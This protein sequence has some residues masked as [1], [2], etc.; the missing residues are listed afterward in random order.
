MLSHRDSLMGCKTHKQYSQRSAA[1]LLHFCQR[2]NGCWGAGR[3]RWLSLVASGQASSG[4]PA[5]ANYEQICHLV[6]EGRH[7]KLRGTNPLAAHGPRGG[8]QQLSVGHQRAW[9]LVAPEA[10]WGAAE[11]GNLVP[12]CTGANHARGCAA[13][14]WHCMLGP[15]LE[16]GASPP[17]WRACRRAPGCTPRTAQAQQ[18]Q[19]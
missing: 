19:L 4:T 6:F 1:A 16:R 11:A 2:S 18:L 17:C 8:E 15:C 14:R 7:R 13:W 9:E 3:R 10:P 5:S 12:T